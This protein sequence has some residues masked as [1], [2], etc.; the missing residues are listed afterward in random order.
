MIK[1]KRPK[2][3]GGRGNERGNWGISMYRAGK[4]REWRRRRVHNGKSRC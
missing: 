3:Q 2:E 4:P 1:R